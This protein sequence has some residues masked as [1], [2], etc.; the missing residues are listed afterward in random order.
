[1]VM[2]LEIVFKDFNDQFSLEILEESIVS[3]LFLNSM[4]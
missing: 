2:F 4:K 1:M 3:L